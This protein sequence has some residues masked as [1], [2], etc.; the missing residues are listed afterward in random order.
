[1]RHEGLFTP[2]ISFVTGSQITKTCADGSRGG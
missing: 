1:M 2:I